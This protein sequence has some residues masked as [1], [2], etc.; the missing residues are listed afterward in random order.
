MS[1]ASGPCLHLGG[2]AIGITGIILGKTEL[3]AIKQG[4]ASKAGENYAKVGFY[5]GLAGAIFS[6]FTIVLCGA[7]RN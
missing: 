7:L 1:V 4:K 2:V 3:D 5:V 6:L